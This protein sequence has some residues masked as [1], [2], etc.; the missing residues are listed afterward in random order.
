[1]FSGFSERGHPVVSHHDL[2]RF[3]RVGEMTVLEHKVA[4]RAS[5]RLSATALKEFL[6]GGSMYRK[7]FSSMVEH[8]I[9]Y[10]YGRVRV[11]EETFVLDA[12]ELS[13]NFGI[14][15]TEEEVKR[16]KVSVSPPPSPPV[17]E[18]RS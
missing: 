10:E 5:G 14:S 17:P 12:E 4:T 18:P 2:I 7:L 13:R 11:E 3:V 9:P 8:I 15:L 6:S 16:I 1:M